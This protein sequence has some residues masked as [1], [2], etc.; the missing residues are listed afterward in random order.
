M[1]TNR[2]SVSKRDP[3][4]AEAIAGLKEM[5]I[6]PA[7]RGY[8]GHCIYKVALYLR[9]HFEKE[10]NVAGLLAPHFAILTMIKSVGSMT[11]TEL[12][13]CM[14]TDKATMVRFIDG[15]EEQ[16]YLRR[17]SHAS[18]RRA[19]V[20]R[21]TKEGEKM[22]ERL[23]IK[24]KKVENE[25]FAALSAEEKKTLHALVSKLVAGD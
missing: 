25:F 5:R 24:R 7:L 9:A 14:A 23:Q 4:P 22:L 11:Q 19:K 6:H 10:M 15:L 18:D 12:G 8:L 16:G 2:K 21:L 13:G 1:K 17:A 20:L 3:K